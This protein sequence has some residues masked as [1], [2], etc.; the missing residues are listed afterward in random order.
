MRLHGKIVIVTGGGQGVGEAISKKLAKEDAKVMIANINEQNAEATA[1]QIK[2]KGGETFPLKV[3]VSQ[4]TDANEWQRMRPY[5]VPVDKSLFLQEIIIWEVRRWR[6]KFR[7]ALTLF[8][9]GTMS[10]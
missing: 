9:P 8:F 1:E 4:L 2:S 3:N 6:K 5:G 7:R 10:G